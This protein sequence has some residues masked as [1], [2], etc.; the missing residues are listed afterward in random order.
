MGEETSQ[1]KRRQPSSTEPADRQTCGSAGAGVPATARHVVA[2]IADCFPNRQLTDG[3]RRG[4]SGA[5]V[6][7]V[8]FQCILP[9]RWQR[10][11]ARHRPVQVVPGKLE[12]YE[13][14][15][16]KALKAL[17]PDIKVMV[18]RNTL[19]TLPITLPSHDL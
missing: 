19:D 15:T 2:E 1:N 5:D 4:P 6:S 10:L 7:W 14:E 9:L 13:V 3:R 12:Q 18:S 17:R 16:A 11:R 8:L